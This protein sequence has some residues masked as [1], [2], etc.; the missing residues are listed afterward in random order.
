M[1]TSFSPEQLKDPTLAEANDILRACVHCG[2]CTATCPTYVLLGDELDSP[3][4][5]I[6]LIKEMLE[7][8]TPASAEVATHIDRCL[9]CYACMS[10]CPSGVNYMHLIEAG[11]FHVERTA[12]R[13]LVQR[14][15]RRLIGAVL[16]YPARLRAA[17][18]LGRVVKPF[19]A[20]LPRKLRAMIALAPAAEP[21]AIGAGTQVF[22]AQGPG[23]KR[24]ALLRGCVQQVVEDHITLATIR[25]LNRHGIEVVVVGEALCCGAL[26]HHLGQEQGRLRAACT[27]RA[28]AA[29]QAREPFDA[30]VVNAS[31]CGTMVKDYG[32]LFRD[33]PALAREAAAIAALARDI[34]E[35][36][37]ELK[38]AVQPDRNLRVAY[39]SACSLQHGQ[40]ITDLPVR[41]LQD[42][43]FTVVEPLERHLCCGSAGTYNMLEPEIAGA[44]RDRKL[45]N[46]AALSAD[47]ICS[48]NLGCMVQLR[49]GCRVPMV[50]TVELLDWATG[51]P[52]PPALAAR[53]NAAG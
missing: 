2:F 4:G 45:A 51:G 33:D 29:A 47:V 6:M 8:N 42:A 18:A 31:G 43:G 32:H 20:L 21:P 36:L 10:T 50:H 19:A 11:R 30:I 9:S 39:Q 52:M 3:R 23:R 38:L 7:R 17:L 24:V 35:V 13:P 14:S 16:P 37:A 46:L 41:L 25:V 12:A 27:V 44:L 49:A 48:A 15:L 5:R 28:W 53:K 1:Q 40:R 26:N 34:S 22:P